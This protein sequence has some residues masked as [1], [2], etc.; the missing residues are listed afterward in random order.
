MNEGVSIACLHFDSPAPIISDIEALAPECFIHAQ[1]A[2][3]CQNPIY[4]LREIFMNVECPKVNIVRADNA[5]CKVRVHGFWVR[6]DINQI[7]DRLLEFAYNIMV[8]MI[9]NYKDKE[10]FLSHSAR[11]SFFK[12]DLVGDRYKDEDIRSFKKCLLG[13][14][15]DD[16]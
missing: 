11:L 4:I 6:I 10:P 16:N 13:S 15:K 3:L 12:E 7:V 8:T 5:T 2:T 14:L 9:T 1:S